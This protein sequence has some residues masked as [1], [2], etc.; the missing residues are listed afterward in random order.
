MKKSKSSI[1]RLE[2]IFPERF[3]DFEGIA[4]PEEPVPAESRVAMTVGKT[5][6]GILLPAK[7]IFVYLF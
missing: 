4:G 3:D 7:P 6:D 2:A 1:P 5:K